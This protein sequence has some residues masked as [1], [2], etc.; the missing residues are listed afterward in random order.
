MNGVRVAVWDLPT[1]LFHWTLAALV[2]VS[3]WSGETGGLAFT[4]HTLAG[5]AILALVLFRLGWGVVGGEYARFSSFVRGPARVRASLRELL[6]PTPQ[7]EPGHNP[8]GGW[9]ILA[10]LVS[11]TLQVFTGL[12]A[13]DDIMN[14]GPWAAR[15]GDDWSDRLSALHEANFA[16]LLGLVGLHVAAIVYHRLRKGENLTRAMITGYQSLPV[17]PRAARVAPLGLALLLLA[18]SAGIVTLLVNL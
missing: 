11:L 4:T 16:L 2:G 17:A 6:A 9:M 13:N 18:A 3:W 10:L 8:L 1:R 14:E 7:R 15:V 12:C 5:S